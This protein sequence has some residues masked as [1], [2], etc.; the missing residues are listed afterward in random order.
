MSVAF[1]YFRALR[2]SEKIAST[3]SFESKIC[4]SFGYGVEAFV[5]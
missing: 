4:L 5:K 1:E 2:V 3:D